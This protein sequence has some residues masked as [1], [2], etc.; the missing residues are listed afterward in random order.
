MLAASVLTIRWIRIYTSVGSIAL[1]KWGRTM[2]NAL[3]FTKL[4]LLGSLTTLAAC[5]SAPR[6]PALPSTWTMTTEGCQTWNRTPSASSTETVTWD[7]ACVGGYVDGPGTLTWFQ[8]GSYSQ[9]FVGTMRAG[10]RQGTGEYYWASGDRYQGAFENDLRTG[11]GSYT[12]SSGDTYSGDFIDGQRT[13]YGV[14]TYA[15]GNRFEGDQSNGSFMNGN[16]TAANGEAIARYTDGKRIALRY[17]P[18]QA[19]NQTSSGAGF[20]A[21]LGAIAQGLAA[22]GGKN[23]AQLQAAASVMN[24]TAG[25]GGNAARAYSA[26]N[27]AASG[28]ATSGMNGTETQPMVN[29]CLSLT[30]SHKYSM[31]INNSCGFEVSMIYCYT[32]ISNAART[33]FDVTSNACT[34]YRTS[35]SAN[36]VVGASSFIEVNAPDNTNPV[37]FIA[38]K[39]AN[40]GY[41]EKLRFDGSRLNGQCHY[42][43]TTAGSG[44][45]GFGAVR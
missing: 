30:R 19:S 29:N 8:D 37:E 20:G 28:N 27:T 45:R 15:N 34:N 40:D 22:A 24:S 10:K 9:R 44:S 35:A 31:R 42:R 3:D 21:V 39:S 6:A 5:A 14:Y 2:R 36:V 11:K 16:L 13:G 33:G 43:Q 1:R 18:A 12:W 4:I 17:E 26:P 38:C 41:P 25:G 7:G 23:S 32:S